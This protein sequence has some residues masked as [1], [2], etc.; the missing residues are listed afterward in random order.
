MKTDQQTP[1]PAYRVTALDNFD[2]YED[3]GVP[4]PCWDAQ[5][6]LSVAKGILERSLAHEHDQAK[7]PTCS[8]EL[9]SRWDDFGD[10]P[11]ISPELDPP[12]DPSE[13]ARQR[14]AEICSLLK[15]GM[16]QETVICAADFPT[17]TK[18]FEIEDVP[19]AWPPGV[20]P[21]N[22]FNGKRGTLSHRTSMKLAYEH[23][24]TP[25]EFDACVAKSISSAKEDEQQYPSGSAEGGDEQ[26][27][28]R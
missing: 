13:Y 25:K 15:P 6:A 24:I 28:S 10:Y 22:A 8:E 1:S 19:I 17:G 26:D 12:F 21:V 23:E 3:A 9:F 2:W 4:T 27:K 18:F 14:A 20:E 11:S 5:H 7:D 16:R